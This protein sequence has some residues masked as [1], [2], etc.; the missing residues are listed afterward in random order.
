MKVLSKKKND[1]ASTLKNYELP[2][3]EEALNK[4]RHYLYNP[5]YNHH[6]HVYKKF[7]WER[8]QH[9]VKLGLKAD[10]GSVQP[11]PDLGPGPLPSVMERI[12][13]GH[14]AGPMVCKDLLDHNNDREITK[15]DLHR[16]YDDHTGESKD[17]KDNH[18][19]CE[20]FVALDMEKARCLDEPHKW[21]I[22]DKVFHKLDENGDGKLTLFE[23]YRNSMHT[24][25]DPRRMKMNFELE[26]RERR[27][28]ARDPTHPRHQHRMLKVPNH[29]L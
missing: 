18:T 6:D 10:D 8:H 9:A 13:R 26:F 23:C 25:G 15:E 21:A 28:A 22:A 19:L 7:L 3:R 20:L 24:S 2:S 1:D 4:A 16:V 27:K 14:D 5:N 29:E 11:P 17:H 12:R